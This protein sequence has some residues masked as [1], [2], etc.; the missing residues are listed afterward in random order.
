M[1]VPEPIPAT[2]GVQSTGWSIMS[3]VLFIWDQASQQ[4]YMDWARYRQRN[5][6]VLFP[7]E[8]GS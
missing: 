4:P 7:E 1:L 8:V 2:E 6:E 3:D 5:S